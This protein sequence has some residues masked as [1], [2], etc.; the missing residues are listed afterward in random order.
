M[1]ININYMLIFNGT[2][3]CA[4]M[5]VGQ[6]RPTFNRELLHNRPTRVHV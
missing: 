2:P 5:N 6:Y 3:N 1:K 4:C